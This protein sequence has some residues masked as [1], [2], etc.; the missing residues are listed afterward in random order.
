V[1]DTSLEVDAVN[2]ALRAAAMGVLLLSPVALSA[3]SAGQVAQTAEQERDKVGGSAIAGD[4]TLRDA[5]LVYPSTGEYAAGSDARLV[6]AIS[7]SS[8]QDD[9]LVDITGEGFSRAQLSGTST[10]SAPAGGAS[11]LNVPVPANSNVFIGGT[12]GPR[13]VLTGLQDPLTAGEALDV[14]MSF[15]RAGDVELRVLVGTPT[16]TLPRGEAFDFHEEEG[17]GGSEQQLGGS[18]EE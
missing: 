17:G 13:V 15:Q 5:R 6:V 8:Q 18:S 3:C 11:G 1:T 7:N 16:R 14:T 10:V 2:R 4:L 12:D 9:T